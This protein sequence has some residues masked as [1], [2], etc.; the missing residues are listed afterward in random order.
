MKK[1]LYILTLFVLVLFGACTTDN[2]EPTLEQE[3]PIEGNI[4]SAEDLLGIIKGCLSRMTDDTYYG[5]N[6]IINNEVR[7]DNVFANGNSGRFSTVDQFTYNEASNMGIWTRAYRVISSANLVIEADLATIEGDET[8]VKHLQGSA[9]ALR[10]LAHFDLMKNYGQQHVGGTLGVPYVTKFKGNEESPARNTVAEVKTNLYSDLEMAFSLMSPD[11][12]DASK[13]FISQITAKAIESN[14][15]LYFGDY[16]RCVT[17]SEEVIGSG[18]YSIIPA[19][20]YV[21]SFGQIATS[22]SI[23]ELAFNDSDNQGI[24]GLAYIYRGSNYGDIECFD[25]TGIF[26][27]GDVRADII[28]FEYIETDSLLRNMYKYPKVNGSDNV[29]VIRYEEIILNYAEALLNTSGDA[30]A[31]INLLRSFRGLPALGAVTIDE[32]LYER[33]AELM[34]EG[35]RF[36]DLVRTGNPIAK[37]GRDVIPA[38][39]NVMAFPI[40][41]DEMDV[42]SNMEQNDGY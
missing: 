28:A 32:I 26:E 35:H 8:Y 38:N 29:N 13:E 15:A 4:N 42:N 27:S 16:A 1:N 36:T 37:P 40:P 9:Y 10:A 2:L 14:V 3:K 11:H 18:L 41:T 31:Q 25:T 7:T 22:N 34:F 23:F 24:S 33:R 6:F 39:D 21:T 20:D 12:F 30:L 19:A 17:A 5:R